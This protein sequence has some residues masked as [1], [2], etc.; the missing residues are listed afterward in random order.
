MLLESY[1]YVQDRQIMMGGRH[2]G[3][4]R[5]IALLI[6]AAALFY[7]ASRISHIQIGERATGG[8]DGASMTPQQRVIQAEKE[9]R[10]AAEAA[11]AATMRQAE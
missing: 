11:R 9:A 2:N 8:Y 5:F 10:E 7:G 3:C 1:V 4:M 6:I